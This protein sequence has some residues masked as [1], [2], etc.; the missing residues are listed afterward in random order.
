MANYIQRGKLDPSLL[1]L[2]PHVART[3]VCRADQLNALAEVATKMGMPEAARFLKREA[4]RR[5]P[6]R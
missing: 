1:D 4:R 3:K 6:R 2:V 5:R